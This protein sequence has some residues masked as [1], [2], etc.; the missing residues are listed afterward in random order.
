MPGKKETAHQRSQRLLRQRESLNL[1]IA[2]NTCIWMLKKD[3]D[4]VRIVRD[5]LQSIG[6]W[7]EISDG[8]D[9]MGAGGVSSRRLLETVTSCP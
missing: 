6:K 5:H 1:K 3:D 7:V 8:I 2:R 9:E 4:I